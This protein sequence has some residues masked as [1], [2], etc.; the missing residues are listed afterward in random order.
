MSRRPGPKSSLDVSYLGG[1]AG[2][3]LKQFDVIE[4]LIRL[5]VGDNPDEEAARLLQELQQLNREAA[6]LKEEHGFHVCEV[7]DKS[8]CDAKGVRRHIM[9]TADER[10]QERMR[11]LT[12][13]TCR[14]CERSFKKRESVTKHQNSCPHS[15]WWAFP[16]FVHFRRKGAGL[17]GNY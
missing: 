4:K 12:T 13:L 10:H 5:I 9:T 16:S 6:N 2:V 8:F 14:Y 11:E 15:E 7:C 17:M 1:L 3:S